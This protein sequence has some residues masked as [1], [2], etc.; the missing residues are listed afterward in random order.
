[1]TSVRAHARAAFFPLALIVA[2]AAGAQPS[3]PA[4]EV[5]T[6]G[7]PIRTNL[8]SISSEIERRVETSF[9][10]TAR[11]RGIDI[12]Y[13]VARDPIRLMMV[14]AGL[15]SSTTIRYAL[16]A[17]RGRFPCIS[18]GVAEARR[19]ADIKLHT[20]FT[21]DPRWRLRSTTTL[22]PV[23]YAKPCAVTWLDIDITRRFVAPVVEQQL[24]TAARIIDRQVPALTDFKPQASQIWNALQTPFELAPRTWLVLEPAAVSLAPVTGANTVVTTTLH[25]R[26]HTRVVVGEKPPVAL[27]PLPALTATPAAA[28]PAGIRIPFDLQLPYDEASRIASR[29]YAG[30]T[31]AVDGRKLT[32]ESLRLAPTANGRVLIEAVIDYRGGRLRNYRGPVVLEG[33]PR[34]DAATSSIVIPDLDYSLDPKRRG[35]FARMV[36][37]AAHASIRA[38]LRESARF[39]LASRITEVRDEVTRALNRPLG[40]NVLLRGGADAIEPVSAT[41]LPSHIAVRIVATGHAEVELR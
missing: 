10:G 38:R 39:S 13:D 26:A 22:L 11:E 16:Q 12:E 6:I 5:S 9:R 4:P 34:F 2:W 40:S 15:H 33:T 37:R 23:H 30:K 18:C 19:L 32:V 14:G 8:G 41:S 17:C 36:E 3:P 31:Y 7:I 27:R 28:S 29:D 35:L 1:M 21:W 20:R 24:T 25:L